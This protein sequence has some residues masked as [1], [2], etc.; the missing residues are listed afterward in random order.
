VEA[1]AIRPGMEVLIRPVSP[2]R[3]PRREATVVELERHPGY[4]RNRV[5]VRYADTGEEASLPLG[6]VARP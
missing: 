1:K 5:R 6:R 2:R 3:L 4:R